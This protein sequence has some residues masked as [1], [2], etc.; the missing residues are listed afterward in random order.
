MKQPRFE[1]FIGKNDQFF[2][3]LKARNGR[4][5][6]QSEGYT[7]KHNCE[8]GI[9]V[10]QE[11]RWETVINENWFTVTALNGECLGKSETY[12]SDRSMR[13]GIRSV[14]ANAPIAIVVDLTPKK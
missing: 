10:I 6:L 13:K 5:I 7:Q 1:I 9:S 3:R 12:K 4:I 2:F 11:M 14:Y 8:G